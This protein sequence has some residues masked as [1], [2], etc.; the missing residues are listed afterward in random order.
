MDKGDDVMDDYVYEEHPVVKNVYTTLWA[1]PRQLTK[2]WG[3]PTILTRMHDFLGERP[4]V[5]FGLTDGIDDPDAVTVDIDP[6]NNPTVVADWDDLPFPDNHFTFAF[7]DPP[8]DKRYVKGLR[9]IL[10]VTRRRV[11][12]LHQLVYPNPKGW[13]KF[14]IIGVTTG[15]NMRIR[16][17]QIYDRDPQTELGEFE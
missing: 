5:Y 4:D 15:P 10:R 3:C 7:W 13:T 16:C 1:C 14:A 17:L 9:E 6:S 11:A 2:G 12:I 8:Y